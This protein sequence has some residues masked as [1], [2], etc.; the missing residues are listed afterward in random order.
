MRRPVDRYDDKGT[1]DTLPFA[2]GRNQYGEDVQFVETFVCHICGNPAEHLPIRHCEA[3]GPDDS[4]FT[5]RM[6]SMTVERLY[7][8]CSDHVAQISNQ[9]CDEHGWSINDGPMEQ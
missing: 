5:H 9:V 6:T 8:A 3:H 1:F 7:Y 2:A 4:N